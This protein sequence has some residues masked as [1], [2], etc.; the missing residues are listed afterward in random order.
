MVTK[1]ADIEVCI[2]NIIIS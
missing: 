1:M 2:H